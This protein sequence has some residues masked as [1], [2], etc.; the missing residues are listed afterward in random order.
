LSRYQDRF[1]FTISSNRKEDK[2][3]LIRILHK[4]R[5]VYEF[6]LEEGQTSYSVSKDFLPNEVLV[7]NLYDDENR[8]LSQRLINNKH[9]IESFVSFKKKYQFFYADQLSEISIDIDSLSNYFVDSLIWNVRVVHSEYLDKGS[10]SDYLEVQPAQWDEFDNLSSNNKLYIRNLELIGNAVDR[11]YLS[12]YDYD[13]KDYKYKEDFSFSLSG[14]LKDPD[15]P[16]YTEKGKVSITSMSSNLYYEEVL[17]NEAGEFRF[18]KL[19]YAPNHFMV[20]QARKN[21]GKDDDILEG[22]RYLKIELDTNYTT[23]ERSNTAF[24]YRQDLIPDTFKTSYHI[25]EKTLSR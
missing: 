14:V 6:D 17:S 3:Q 15:E 8:L 22:D 24:H 21:V 1:I 2:S 12:A 18:D 9:E 16:K 5:M 25:V 19:P 4:G 7:V 20:I 23:A 13:I 11:D 10:R